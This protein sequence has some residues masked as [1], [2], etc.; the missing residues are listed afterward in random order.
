MVGVQSTR[1]AVE[2]KYCNSLGVFNKTIIQLALL[3]I[4][5]ANSA[6][7]EIMQN[8]RQRPLNKPLTCVIKPSDTNPCHSSHNLGCTETGMPFVVPVHCLSS[9]MAS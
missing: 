2:L 1:T 8:C 4:V 3:W 7:L 6:L 9:S 5:I